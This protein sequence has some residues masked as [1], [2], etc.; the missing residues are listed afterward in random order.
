MNDGVIRR[1][2]RRRVGRAVACAGATLGVLLCAGVARAQVAPLFAPDAG[3]D[4]I[5]EREQLLAF[6]P[7]SLEDVLR[8]LIGVVVSRRGAVGSLEYINVAGGTSGRCL[9]SLDGIDLAE[10]ELAFPRLYALPLAA[11]ERIQVFR[12]T[13]PARIEIWTRR[14]QA[15][16][17]ATEIDLGRGDIETR[18]RR[19]QFLLPPRSWWVGMRYDEL[20]RGKDDFRPASTTAAPTSFGAYDG[21]G[22]SLAFGFEREGGE[23]VRVFVADAFDNA[24]G[25]YESLDETTGSS[26]VLGSVRWW[27]PLGP[28][29]LVLDVTQQGWERVRGFASG[30]QSI[31]ESQGRFGADLV[32]NSST[33][34][35]GA[36]RLRAT[37][38]E[39][40]R[41]GTAGAL[42]A[43]FQRYDA[44]AHLG[45]DGRIGWNAWAGVHR[46]SDL[47][48]EWSARA[49]FEWRRGS[50]SSELQGGR[51]VAFAGW[52]EARTAGDDGV[53]A[54]SYANA[55]LRREGAWS[56]FA[57]AATAKHFE[58]LG[59][60]TALFFPQLGRGPEDLAALFA[61]AGLHV[62]AGA[63]PWRV[64][65]RLSWLP[66][67]QGDRSGLPEM[68]VALSTS[69]AAAKLFQGDLQVTLR[70]RGRYETQRVFTDTVALARY[71]AI[72]LRLDF[73]VLERMLIYWDVQNASDTAY[74]IHPG[75]E[76]PGRA[77]LVGVR[78]ELLD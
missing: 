60:A 72:D 67:V 39:G 35:R 57:L 54:G 8:H 33:G 3:A 9:L 52:G 44:E 36:L 12:S 19:V 63:W 74:E 59:D 1:L 24:H 68:Q 53:R 45:S 38:V 70:A 25:S 10:P 6:E 64:D 43:R 7:L 21:R 42:D 13:V 77:S 78:V 61:D 5:L 76:M 58:A 47:T 29:D 51:G 62:L 27:R 50:W 30:R 26:R 32:R 31:T 73:R 18:V 56:S 22:R 40:E 48:Q 65:T 2:G 4:E 14:S 66:H 28:W 20:L 23:R 37:D 71:G 49:A 11:V 16:A 17:T 55:A 75:V 69:L 15:T 46:R 41:A 34:L